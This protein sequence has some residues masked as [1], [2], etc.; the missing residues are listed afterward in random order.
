MLLLLLIARVEEL[1][2]LLVTSTSELS[3]SGTLLGLEHI[4]VRAA[5]EHAADFSRQALDDVLTELLVLT[6]VLA[7]KTELVCL[8]H[9][10]TAHVLDLGN[11]VEDSALLSLC[12]W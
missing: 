4:C 11:D 7:F 8:V 12:S 9:V 6:N 5:R 3:L 10:A 1:G 2:V